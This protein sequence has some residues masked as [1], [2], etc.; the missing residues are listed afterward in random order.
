MLVGCEGIEPPAHAAYLFRYRRVFPDVRSV[1]KQLRGA[2][3]TALGGVSSITAS[4]HIKLL[5]P[6]FDTVGT[7]PRVH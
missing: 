5:S 2:V 1:A 3:Y 6:F 4:A 7:K